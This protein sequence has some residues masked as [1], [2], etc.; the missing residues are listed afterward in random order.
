[1]PG[2]KPIEAHPEIKAYLR[3]IGATTPAIARAVAVFGDEVL[4]LWVEQTS[5]AL[6]QAVRRPHGRMPLGR[7]PLGR[8]PLD[9]L[10]AL[11]MR[12]RAEARV[13]PSPPAGY[14]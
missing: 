13:H 14:F 8:M 2:R 5:E 9:D 11:W 3:E 1:M 10:A 6:V 7:M 4:R 12:Q